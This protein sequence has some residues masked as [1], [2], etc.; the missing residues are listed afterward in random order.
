MSWN[1]QDKHILELPLQCQQLNHVVSLS[2]PVLPVCLPPSNKALYKY[3]YMKTK[4]IIMRLIE[5]S[6]NPPKP[7]LPIAQ[8][9]SH[10]EA[11][12]PA[13]DGVRW[14]HVE[15]RQLLDKAL[16]DGACEAMSHTVA[17]MQLC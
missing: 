4:A 16:L 11:R 2:T 1:L 3:N 9:G 13:R 5:A 7:L 17:R 15:A 12:T 10:T 14:R 6:D 8:R